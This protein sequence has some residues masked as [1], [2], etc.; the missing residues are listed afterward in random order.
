MD[1]DTERELIERAMAGDAAAVTALYEAHYPSL[2]AFMLRMC[3]RPEDA[4]DVVQEAFVRVLKNLDR[5]DFRFRFSTWLFTIA[6]RWYLNASA[7]H[8]P[9]FDTSVVDG[10]SGGGSRPA[11]SPTAEEADETRAARHLIAEARAARLTP[12]QDDIFSL[13]YEVNLSVASIAEQKG[14]PEGTVKSHLHRARKQLRSYV[15]ESGSPA[16]RAVLE[17]FGLDESFGES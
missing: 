6:K 16:A 1:R 2:Y 7:K 3:R 9:L 5:F 4:E 15:E 10:Q 8:R 14:S 13:Y 12:D 11:E 17:A